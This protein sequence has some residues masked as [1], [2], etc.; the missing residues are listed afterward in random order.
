GANTEARNGLAGGRVR[1]KLSLE[2]FQVK[3]KVQNIYLFN[4][5][6]GHTNPPIL[7]CWFQVADLMSRYAHRRVQIHRAPQSTPMN[8]CNAIATARISSDQIDAQYR[9]TLFETGRRQPFVTS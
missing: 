6:F 9:A 8:C 5:I 4:F 2:I 7:S 1:V 3:S